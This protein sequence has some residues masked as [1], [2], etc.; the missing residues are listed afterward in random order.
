[1]YG[2]YDTSSQAAGRGNVHSATLASG[3]YWYGHHQRHYHH[4][5]FLSS[6]AAAHQR[7]LTQPH[8]CTPSTVN[9]SILMHTVRAPAWTMPRQLPHQYQPGPCRGNCHISTCLLQPFI[10]P[11]GVFIN[12]Q[13][14]AT[15]GRADQ[16]APQAA[17]SARS[18]NSGTVA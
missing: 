4:L 7:C 6:P 10:N 9:G 3:V 11:P 18:Y 12:A 13:V 2:T 8:L 1:M 5:C 15:A 16:K 17:R 14:C